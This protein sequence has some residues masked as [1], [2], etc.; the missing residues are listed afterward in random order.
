MK[1]TSTPANPPARTINPVPVKTKD[2]PVGDIA[3]SATTD[4]VELTGSGP[5]SA[6][7]DIDTPF[8]ADKVEAIKKAIAAGTFEVNADKVA[9]G[10]IET[11]RNLLKK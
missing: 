3:S 7:T 2:T 4:K 6:L 10:L 8:D 11:V 1:I 5:A 9:S